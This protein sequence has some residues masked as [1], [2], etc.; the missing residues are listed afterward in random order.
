[1]VVSWSSKSIIFGGIKQALHVGEKQGGTWS[2]L[3]CYFGSK[4]KLVTTKVQ[5][6]RTTGK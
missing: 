3:G 4:R 5:A 1:L 2:S 6:H